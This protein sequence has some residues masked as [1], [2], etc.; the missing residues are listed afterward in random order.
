ML[1]HLVEPDAQPDDRILDGRQIL[2]INPWIKPAK[3]L[4]SIGIY[5]VTFAWMVPRVHGYTR[6]RQTIAWGVLI[7]MTTISVGARLWMNRFAWVGTMSKVPLAVAVT[8]LHLPS[9]P[10][11]AFW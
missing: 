1:L 7:A 5:L 8:L 4:L 3:F 10:C 6:S 2:G 11:A 9:Q